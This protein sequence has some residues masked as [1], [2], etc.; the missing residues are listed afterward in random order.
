MVM[1]KVKCFLHCQ[2]NYS[3][4]TWSQADIAIHDLFSP[5]YQV[6][7]CGLCVCEIDSCILRESGRKLMSLPNEPKQE[8]FSANVIMVEPLRFFFSVGEPST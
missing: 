2:L 3:F 6:L 5:S 4:G 7:D 8:M 1:I